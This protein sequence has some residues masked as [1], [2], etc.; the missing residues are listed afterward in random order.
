VVSFS[1]GVLHLLP[2]TT[3]DPAWGVV[4]LLTAALTHYFNNAAMLPALG[5]LIGWAAVFNL[6]SGELLWVGMAVLQAY[7]CS[8]SSSSL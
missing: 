8:A 4:L 2:G 6:L 3:L 1:W 5:V 7:W